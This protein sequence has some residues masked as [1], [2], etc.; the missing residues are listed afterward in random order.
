MKGCPLSRAALCPPPDRRQ[1]TLNFIQAWKQS[2]PCVRLVIVTSWSNRCR[3]SA[4]NVSLRQA[5]GP[6]SSGSLARHSYFYFRPI[7]VGLGFLTL[8]GDSELQ[9]RG[10]L[11]RDSAKLPPCVAANTDP[12]IYLRGQPLDNPITAS[13]NCRFYSVERSRS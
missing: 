8:D 4:E 6:S 3:S 7:R 10:S 9:S 5:L 12:M 1:H 11:L 2:V 13:N